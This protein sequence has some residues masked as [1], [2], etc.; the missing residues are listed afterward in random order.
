VWVSAMGSNGVGDRAG[1]IPK[2]RDGTGCVGMPSCCIGTSNRA[3]VCGMDAPICD[4]SDGSAG[5]KCA[6]SLCALSFT[7]LTECETA[8]RPEENL[9]RLTALTAERGPLKGLG[10][11]LT[12]DGALGRSTSGGADLGRIFEEVILGRAGIGAVVA[13]AKCEAILGA[14]RVGA[15]LSALLC[16]TGASVLAWSNP[17]RSGTESIVPSNTEMVAKTISQVR[18]LTFGS[19]VNLRGS[20]PSDMCARIFFILFS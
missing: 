12:K 20:S 4:R 15:S 9:R 7:D 8:R 18:I 17:K 16:V 3:D 19:S 14:I 10:T 2:L 11:T 5:A 1:D 6:G 13:A